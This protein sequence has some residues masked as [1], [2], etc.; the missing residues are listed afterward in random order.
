MR[1]HREQRGEGGFDLQPLPRPASIALLSAA[2]C[3]GFRRSFWLTTAHSIHSRVGQSKELS[4][5]RTSTSSVLG[6]EASQDHNFDVLWVHGSLH[7]LQLLH[8]L[9][10]PEKKLPWVFAKFHLYRVEIDREVVPLLL[11]TRTVVPQES[12]P[13]LAG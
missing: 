11:A 2:H 5:I 12:C 10:N 6:G 8:H 7:F 3:S 9:I 4:N 13:R 1:E